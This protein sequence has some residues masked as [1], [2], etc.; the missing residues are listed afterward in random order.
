MD[1]PQDKVR[2]SFEQQP[3]EELT[4]QVVFRLAEEGEDSWET[5]NLEQVLPP[6]NVGALSAA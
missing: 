3:A 1:A 2:T 4:I 6:S 5:D